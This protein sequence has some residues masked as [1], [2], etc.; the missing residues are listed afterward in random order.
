MELSKA[1]LELIKGS[2]KVLPVLAVGKTYTLQEDM[3]VRITANGNKK[4]YSYLTDDAKKH[5]YDD[6]KGFGILRKG[7]KVT[8]KGITNKNGAVW[9]QIPSGWIRA[10][11]ASRIQYVK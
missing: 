5:G 7:T 9:I 1:G 3:Y 2:R 11:S 4:P 10:V 6:G 8:C